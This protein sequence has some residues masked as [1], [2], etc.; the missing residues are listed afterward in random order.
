MQ[1]KSYIYIYTKKKDIFI[2]NKNNPVLVRFGISLETFKDCCF[3]S[4]AHWNTDKTLFDAFLPVSK[5]SDGGYGYLCR[6]QG[7]HEWKRRQ[8]DSSKGSAQ[9]AGAWRATAAAPRKDLD[10]LIWRSDCFLSLLMLK[11]YLS[12]K[13]H[14]TYTKNLNMQWVHERNFECDILFISWIHLECTDIYIRVYFDC[15]F[16]FFFNLFTKKKKNPFI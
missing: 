12:Q 4:W 16:F 14:Q 11:V 5:Q 7:L 1:I 9:S 13:Q 10:P 6:R 8:S 3:T 15:L 2:S